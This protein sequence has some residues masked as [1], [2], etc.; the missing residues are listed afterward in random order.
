MALPTM[1]AG[2]TSREF[3]RI[4]GGFASPAAGTSPAGGLDIDNAGNLATDGDITAAGNVDIDGDL[5]VDT[6]TLHVD[7]VNGRVGIGTGSPAQLL[8]LF[9]SGTGSVRF[10]FE[11]AEGF[12]DLL[13]DGG[14]FSIL[15]KN[16]NFLMTWQ[17][18]GNIIVR[19]PMIPDSDNTRKLGDSAKRWSTVYGVDGDFTGDGTFAGGDVVAGT[20]GGTRGVVTAWDGS[21]GSAPG[22]LKLASP[23]G[24]VWYLFAEDDGTLK[25]HSALPTLNADGTEIGTQT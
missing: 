18:G 22:C 14:D 24:T 21:G 17:D 5:T 25:I 3:L 6:D 20:D 9:S 13:V 15:D 4:A 11:N 1:R 19:L 10:R 12:S 8:H 2:I 23:N 7:A 16:G